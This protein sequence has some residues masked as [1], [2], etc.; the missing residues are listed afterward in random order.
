MKHG[1]VVLLLKK[2]GLDVTDLK[3]FRPIT[4]LST[5]FKI[6]ERVTLAR[7]KPF[8]HQITVVCS[9]LIANDIQPRQPFARQSMV[10][11]DVLTMAV[12]LL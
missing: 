8:H 12:L 1:I 9:Q 7:L 3:N 4:K 6:F 11:S 10:L 2:P 5:I